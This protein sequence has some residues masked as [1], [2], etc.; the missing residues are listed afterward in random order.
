LLIGPSIPN[1]IP[2]N[3]QN[4][5]T[6]KNAHTPKQMALVFVVYRCE[7]KMKWSSRW[8]NMRTEKYN[9]GSCTVIVSIGVGVK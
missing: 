8:P 3:H 1:A 4:V 7:E 5:P 9:V 2:L 6:I